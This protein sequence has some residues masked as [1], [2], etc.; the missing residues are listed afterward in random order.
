MLGLLFVVVI[1]DASPSLYL[2]C[3]EFSVQHRYSD[4]FSPIPL[5]YANPLI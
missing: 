5:K 3:T 2:C 1:Q 4:Q